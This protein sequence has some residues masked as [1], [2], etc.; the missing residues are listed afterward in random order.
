MTSAAQD[1]TVNMADIVEMQE[2]ILEVEFS[3]YA[4]KVEDIENWLLRRFHGVPRGAFN[5]QVIS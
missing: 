1:N 4:Y 5:V 2:N 3:R